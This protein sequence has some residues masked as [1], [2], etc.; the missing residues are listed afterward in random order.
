MP[1]TESICGS[2][3]RI[4]RGDRGAR[5]RHPRRSA[6]SGL[7]FDPRPRK[8]RLPR[9]PP[10]FRKF[11]F[12]RGEYRLYLFTSEAFTATDSE[13]NDSPNDAQDLG[14]LDTEAS[15][16]ATVDASDPVDVFQFELRRDLAS[17]RATL[18]NANPGHNL[19]ILDASETELAAS[20]PDHDGATDPDAAANQLTAGTYYVEVEQGDGGGALDLVLW[21]EP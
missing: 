18:E 9:R 10:R 5:R 14:V 7:V 3:R 6:F 8:R 13:P 1:A 16:S 12:R 21:L 11:G 20:G 4:I 15:I 17:L 2:T 19:R